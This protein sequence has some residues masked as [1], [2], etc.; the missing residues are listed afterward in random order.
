MCT[1]WFHINA[2]AGAVVRGGANL[3][4]AQH[5]GAATLDLA[6]SG[7]YVEPTCAQAAAAFVK[8]LEAGTI[9]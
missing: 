1:S 2:A 7:I 9:R 6:R 3:G 5:H 4:L 8:L